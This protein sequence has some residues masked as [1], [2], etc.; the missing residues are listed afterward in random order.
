M[1]SD[2]S[3]KIWMVGDRNKHDKYASSFSQLCITLAGFTGAFVVLIISVSVSSRQ[4]ANDC[5]L[6]LLCLLV[7]VMQ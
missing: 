1:N 3:D 4:P 6:Y 5:R 7:L 2:N